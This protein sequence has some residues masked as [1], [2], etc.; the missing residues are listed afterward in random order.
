[1]G[2]R[3]D[4]SPLAEKEKVGASSVSPSKYLTCGEPLVYGT[5]N[6]GGQTSEGLH[7]K[8]LPAI[9]RKSSFVKAPTVCKLGTKLFPP[10][11]LVKSFKKSSLLVWPIAAFLVGL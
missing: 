7:E 6:R 8:A 1:M 3:V 2:A 4:V 10:V 11:V 5:A 9:A